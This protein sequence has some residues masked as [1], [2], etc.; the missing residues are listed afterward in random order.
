MIFA[1]LEFNKIAYFTH[2]DDLREYIM[3]QTGAK[4]FRMYY[5]PQ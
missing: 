1:G 2:I 3:G 4:D 5:D